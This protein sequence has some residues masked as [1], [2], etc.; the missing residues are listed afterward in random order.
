M[1]EL[2]LSYYVLKYSMPRKGFS[3]KVRKNHLYISIHTLIQDWQKRPLEAVYPIIYLD[4]L[5]VKVKDGV[6]DMK[7]I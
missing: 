5:H 3:P 1:D 6:F 4:A 2:V 7:S